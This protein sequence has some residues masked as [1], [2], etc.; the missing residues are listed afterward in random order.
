MSGPSSRPLPSRPGSSGIGGF[1]AA[2]FMPQS[3]DQR[4]SA[5]APE[6]VPPTRRWPTQTPVP[7]PAPTTTAQSAPTDMYAN[8]GLRES[9]RAEVAVLLGRA[10]PALPVP[11]L[12]GA[13]YAIVPLE[14]GPR[15]AF[16]RAG[17]PHTLTYKAVSAARGTATALVRV[18]GPP[19]APSAQIQRAGQAWNNVRH[20]ALLCLKE[21]FTTRQ[22]GAAAAAGNAARGVVPANEVVFAYEFASR[23]DTLHN[24]FL[25]G[26][27]PDHRFHPLAEST[28]WAI[29]SQ[30]LSAMATVHGN[31]FAL[32]DALSTTKVMVTGRNRVRLSCA[33]L[34]DAFDPQ[35]ADHLPIAGPA[36]RHTNHDRAGALQREDL[37]NLGLI[38]ATLAL[39][40]DPKLV[41]SGVIMCADD[42]LVDAIR[43]VCPYSED[44]AVLVGTLRSAARPG[45]QVTTTQVLNVV[46][47]RMALELGNV[48]THC[49]ALET[50]LFAEFDS[51]RMFRLTSLLGFVNERGDAGVDPQ[52]SE[53]GDRYLLK[54]F[55][56]YVFHRVDSHG[57]PVLD[58]AHVVECLSRLDVGSPEQMLLSSR[59]GSSLLVATYEDV[60]RCLLQAVDELRGTRHGIPTR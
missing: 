33:G 15:P 41:R 30:L 28:L 39:R 37:A 21:V 52:W 56:D 47:P 18:V 8:G 40:I 54:L 35:G 12:V 11:E 26:M 31:R 53:T 22:F 51:S 14:P 3:S 2:P 27:P 46:G 44:F 49:D 48:W 50:K 59:D 42:M 13:Y 1:S 32:R 19:P 5:H 4:P 43:R 60:R 29:A 25:G 36:A 7:V 16:G 58:M 20:P 34:S 57:N 24:I 9:A 45:T 6:F 10:H 23:A 38:L 17:G 55:R